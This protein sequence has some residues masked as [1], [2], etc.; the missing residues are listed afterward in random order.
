MVLQP[1]GREHR[2]VFAKSETDAAGENA[3][4]ITGKL[5]FVHYKL[6]F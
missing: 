2:V 4:K 6:Y 1:C 5:H 3:V